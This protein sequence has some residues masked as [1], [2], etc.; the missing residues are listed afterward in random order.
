MTPGSPDVWVTDLRRGVRTRV[1]TAAGT[2]QAPV[3]SPDGR[4]LAYQSNRATD[5][6]SEL[7]ERD[8]GALGPERRLVGAEPGHQL[9]AESWTPDGTA[10]LV[11]DH[12]AD[13]G[14]V[15]LM[16]H[17]SG[18]TSLTPY[19]ADGF[20][21]RQAAVSPDGQWVA[22]TTDETGQLQVVLRSFPDPSR[23]KIPVS[24]NGGAHPRWR[25]D[26]RELFYADGRSHIVAV[27]FTPGANQ[28]LGPAE[29]LFVFPSTVTLAGGQGIGGPFDVF[30]DG[31][32]FLAVTPRTYES[33][34]SLAVT[35]NW[36]DDLR[37]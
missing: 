20:G 11:R 3:W 33:R 19:I 23:A 8:S 26:G 32:Q 9:F 7:Y 28:P 14:R 18:E 22:Y 6:R 10:L 13:R 25:A 36:R 2:D 31:Q 21:N 27:P 37:K 15:D 4:R 16:L 35:L 5:G 17:R 30:P 1:T 29:D 34:V 12:H 24:V